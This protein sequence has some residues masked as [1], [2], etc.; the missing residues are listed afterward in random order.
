M[1]KEEKKTYVWVATVKELKL[2]KQTVKMFQ[3]NKIKAF[4]V[5]K[6]IG[7]LIYTKN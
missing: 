2:A 3:D 1:T 4:H 7:Y 6:S 5:K